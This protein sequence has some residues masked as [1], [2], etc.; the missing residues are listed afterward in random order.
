MGVRKV[1]GCDLC[2]QERDRGDLTRLGVRGLDDRPEDADNVDVGPCCQ[3]KPVSDVL[4][5][6]R[7]AREEV[8]NGK[9]PAAAG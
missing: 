7:D 1:Y 6:A 5:I 3:D 9:A 2:G 8:V 4:A